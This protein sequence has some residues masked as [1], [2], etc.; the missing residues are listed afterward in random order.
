[1][2]R[3]SIPNRKE[4]DL[5][6][7]RAS[8]QPLLQKFLDRYGQPD[9]YYDWGDDPSFFA[10][11]EILGSAE[12][13]T[14]GVCRRD[15]RTAM[16]PGDFVVFFCAR[17]RA[18]GIWEYFYVGLGTV[19]QLLNRHVIWSE[20]EYEPYRRFF[21][22]LARPVSG[23]LRQY[24]TFHRYHPDWDRRASAPY[25]VFDPVETRFDLE[26][27]PL[28]A[29]YE[30]NQGGIEKWR[31]NDPMARRLAALVLPN[32]PSKRGL[33][34]VNI[35]RSHPKMNLESQARRAGGYENLK[36]ELLDLVRDDAAGLGE[37]DDPRLLATGGER[38]MEPM[39]SR[40]EE[41]RRTG[42]LSGQ[43]RKRP[44]SAGADR[45]PPARYIEMTKKYLDQCGPDAKVGDIAKA[46]RADRVPVGYWLNPCLIYL[47]RTRF[48]HLKVSDKV[49][50]GTPVPIVERNG[51]RV[52]VR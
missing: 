2:Y 44:D 32:S 36:A 10:A 37:S 16:R 50:E 22:V 47:D 4:W 31:D 1:M 5:T 49:P 25:I 15:V 20:D 45:V 51:E 33:R 35:Q 28:V 6:W 42:G 27:P 11:S 13:A 52:V 19:K 48:G 38:K 46:M 41:L 17:E 39:T 23:E 26:N 12:S 9:C 43:G 24:E 21:N 3:H 29:S 8:T 14:W 18:H 7:A 40:F 30:R 34:S